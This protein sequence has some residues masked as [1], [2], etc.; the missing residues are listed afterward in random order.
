MPK[1]HTRTSSKKQIPP[2]KNLSDFLDV[3]F[4]PMDSETESIL[5]WASKSTTP[6]FPIDEARFLKQERRSK[7]P[8]ACYFGSA[9]ARADKDGRL[10]NRQTFFEGFY[11]VVLDDIGTGLGSKLPPSAVPEMLAERVTYRVETSP[12]NEQWGF[13]LEVP[14]RELELAKAFQR[15]IIRKA[16]ADGGGC[17]PNKLVRLPAGVNLKEKYED[18]QGQPFVCRLLEL[19]EGN[20]W[21]PEYMLEAVDAGITW[22]ALQK[23]HTAGTLLDKRAGTTAF[24]KEAVYHANLDGLIDPVLEWLNRHDMIVNDNGEWL[25]IICPQADSHT[26]KTENTAGYSPVGRGERPL[27]RGFHCFHD[28][29]KEFTTGLFLYDV[30]TQGGPRVAQ[31]AAIEKYVARYTLDMTSNMFVDMQSDEFTLISPHGF[32]NQLSA[33]VWVPKVDKPEMQAVSE[34]VM[35]MKSPARFRITGQRH[36]TGAPAVI[37]GVNGGYPWLNIWRLPEWGTGPFDQ[38]MVDPFIDFIHYLLP[39]GDDAEWFLDHLAMKAQD[40]FYRGAGVVMSTPVEETGRGSLGMLLGQLWGRANVTSTTLTELINGAATKDNNSWITKDWI[41]I[42]EAKETDMSRKKEGTA[43]ES[44]KRFVETG[45]TPMTIKE[46]WAITKDQFCYGSVIVCSNHGD[47]L[48]LDSGSTRFKRMYNTV[49]KKTLEQFNILHAWARSGFEPHVWRWFLAREITRV[50]KY[51]RQK[52]ITLDDEIHGALRAGRSVEAALAICIAF[53]EKHMGGAV[54]VGEMVSWFADV[55]LVPGL[56]MLTGAEH[57]IRREL[58]NKTQPLVGPSGVGVRVRMGKSQH[59]VR[60]TVSGKGRALA[61][62]VLDG[63]DVK[64]L[65]DQDHKSLREAFSKYCRD[66]QEETD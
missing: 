24:R 21:T 35:F 10:Y 25:D 41:I 62:K 18:A 8:K 47:V 54:L 15:R 3:I 48:P 64:I 26:E 16:G 63:F 31:N 53:S 38:S 37:P 55:S 30:L 44:L 11:V 40:P 36:Q 45:P 20:L 34:Y 13:V 49:T 14:I 23:D 17:M 50:T 60:A 33:D 28:S 65:K 4:G 43:Y 2:E 19:N 27:T 46:K 12:G 52:I 59:K 42:P 32:K 56:D 61:I 7:I 39:N 5:F 57:V 51:G 1:H 29:C 6:G 58:I 66:M 22:G 9:T